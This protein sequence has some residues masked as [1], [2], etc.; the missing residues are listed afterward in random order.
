MAPARLFQVHKAKRMKEK[1]KK[2]VQYI[3]PRFYFT[4]NGTLIIWLGH[5]FY[6]S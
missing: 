4:E 6:F 3:V 2:M 5:E 1:L